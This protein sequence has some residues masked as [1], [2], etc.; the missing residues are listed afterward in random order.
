MKPTA[1][2]NLEER[3]CP[4][5]KLHCITSNCALYNERLNNCALHLIVNNL[6]KLEVAIGKLLT[7]SEGNLKLNLQNRS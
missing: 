4:F 3:N 5:N 1:I 7:P 6:W 2:K